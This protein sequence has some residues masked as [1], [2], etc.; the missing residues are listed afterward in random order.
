MCG[1]LFDF[2]EPKRTNGIL[3]SQLFKINI[4]F[5]RLITTRLEF[6]KMTS[7]TWFEVPGILDME[8]RRIPNEVN[9]VT[10]GLLE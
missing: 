6:Y 2:R 4:N 1:A 10:F 9:R 7:I 8:D 3:N 5:H